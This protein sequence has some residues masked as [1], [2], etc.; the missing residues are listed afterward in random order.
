MKY[1]SKCGDQLK[2]GTEKFCPNCGQ[3]LKN[4]GEVI[5]DT[6]PKSSS[7]NIENTGGSVFGVGISVLLLKYLWPFQQQLK[8]GNRIYNLL[9]AEVL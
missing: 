2:I 8:K 6:N 3:S 1:C 5:T 9:I 7:I 4:G